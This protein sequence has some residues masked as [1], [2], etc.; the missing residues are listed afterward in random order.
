[1]FRRASKKL[2]ARVLS[3]FSKGCKNA[4]WRGGANAGTVK[5]DQIRLLHFTSHSAAPSKRYK[6]PHVFYF[7][8]DSLLDRTAL[9][10]GYNW[11]S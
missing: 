3:I 1:M 5:A 8:F 6:D 4:G 9:K 11:K 7:G 10:S 2:K